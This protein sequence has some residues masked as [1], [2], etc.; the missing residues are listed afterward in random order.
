MGIKIFA[1]L[2]APVTVKER[3]SCCRE[4]RGISTTA[5]LVTKTQH[6]RNPA[7]DM[8]CASHC[9]AQCWG[10]GWSRRLG[11]LQP[12]LPSW[13]LP[14]GAGKARH[15]LQNP[16]QKRQY[17]NAPWQWFTARQ[18]LSHLRGLR[19]KSPQKRPQSIASCTAVETPISSA[20]PVEVSL[21]QLLL[22]KATSSE[23][24]VTCPVTG[25]HW[26]WSLGP[27]KS[28]TLLLGS[29]AWNKQHRAEHDC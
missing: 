23:P 6:A 8:V 7:G 15:P 20:H 21:H 5:H 1:G 27:W 25:Q 2:S 18:V 14:L 3:L 11:T 13:D 16:A 26:K 17:N 29:P 12:G 19:G 4:R 24:W 10:L 22:G 28:C 9:L